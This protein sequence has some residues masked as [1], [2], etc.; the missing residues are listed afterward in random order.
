MKAL[1]TIDG[2]PHEVIVPAVHEI[3]LRQAK[4]L[5]DT[6]QDND[7]EICTAMGVPIEIVERLT[8]KDAEQFVAAYS[9]FMVELG[10]VEP[11]MAHTVTLGEKT[12]TF[13][14]DLQIELA[15]GQLSDIDTLLTTM[16]AKTTLDSYPIVLATI[17]QDGTPYS[18]E[19]SGRMA[20]LVDSFW[21]TP[22]V[23]AFAVCSFFINGAPR[24]TARMRQQ[25]PNWP[26]L[27]GQEQK[28]A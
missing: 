10:A 7:H 23:T 3:T 20:G 8:L 17:A 4:L 21:D 27:N 9:E 24:W 5:L 13:P 6:D 22:A 15:I 14:V 11:S 19:R 25:F 26:S 28:Q 1:F 18:G 16:N 2:K 12:Y